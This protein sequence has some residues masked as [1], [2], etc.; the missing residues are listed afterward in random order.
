MNH[1]SSGT[2]VPD[3]RRAYLFAAAAIL[4]WSTVATA[5][6]LAL[7]GLRPLA[8]LAIAAAT[9]ALCLALVLAARGRLARLARLRPQ[10]LA[11]GALLGLCGPFAYYWVLLGAYDRLPAQ[12]AQPLN[13]VWPITLALLAVPLLG[14]P[15]RR[16]TLP[17]ALLGLAGV[18]VIS[19]R[20]HL[21]ALAVDDP[22]GVALAVGSS[23]LWALYW[24]GC[25]KSQI[26]ED[27]R[28]LLAFAFGALFAG[29]AALLTGATFAAPAPA[30]AA[31]VYVGLFE[32]GVTFVLWQRAL[33][34][35]G[36]AAQVGVLVF[37]TPFLS[38][39]PIRLILGEAIHPATLVGLALIVIG[40]LVESADDLR[41]LLRAPRPA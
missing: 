22:L 38:L 34:L 25:L 6:E 16:R 7:R 30:L 17:A 12:Q 32:M 41:A 33:A 2:P 21:G 24:I 3:R 1:L 11:R 39:I 18:A 15:L 26:D 36:S 8:L 29:A 20:G 28:L 23:L 19:T 14:Q 35:A 4:L 10:D 27:L 13:Y 40:V 31:A 5:F 9:S 37:I